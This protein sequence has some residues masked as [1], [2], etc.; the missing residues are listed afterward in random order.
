VYGFTGAVM[1][2]LDGAR[3]KTGKTPSIQ[4]KRAGA[5]IAKRGRR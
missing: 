2:A 5:K 3:K 1:G 4:S